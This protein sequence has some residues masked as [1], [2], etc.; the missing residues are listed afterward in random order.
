[1]S[2]RREAGSPWA[3]LMLQGVRRSRRMNSTK[4]TR[5]PRPAQVAKST[6]DRLSRCYDLLT[7]FGEGEFTLAALQKLDVR[8][9]ERVLEIGF[10]TGNAI[11][12]LAESVGQAGHVFGIDISQGMYQVAQRKV[13]EAALAPRVTLIVGDARDLPCEPG[14]FDALFLSFT[15]ELFD[16]PEIPKVLRECRRVLVPGGRMCV[17]SLS[18]DQQLGLIGR[19]YEWLHLQLPRLL[20]CRPIPV[21]HVLRNEGFEVIHAEFKSLWGLPV[22]TVLAKNCLERDVTERR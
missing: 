16:T 15:L 19:F 1:V 12:S 22:A 8:E 20:D 21:Q 5:V 14:E 10:G 13:E 11:L 6:Y 17:A 4:F 3:P 18:K 7:R 9:G 2:C